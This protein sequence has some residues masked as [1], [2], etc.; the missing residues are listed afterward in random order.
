MIQTDPLCPPQ[1][2]SAFGDVGIFLTLSQSS[3]VAM[4]VTISLNGAQADSIVSV[5][6]GSFVGTLVSSVMTGDLTQNI[7]QIIPSS[8]G[9]T[10]NITTSMQTLVYN[11]SIVTLNNAQ[12]TYL[13]ASSQSTGT[14]PSVSSNA[15]TYDYVV[16]FLC[17]LGTVTAT[18]AGGQ[19]QLWNMQTGAGANR[20]RSAGATKS[21]AYPMTMSW[22]L[23]PSADY[24]TTMLTVRGYPYHVGVP[25]NVA[26][27]THIGTPN[28][29][30]TPTR[31]VFP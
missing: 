22:T 27:P 17:A 7:Y 20:L 28:H 25:N 11:Y 3:A 21:P 9:D 15:L 14:A 26:V 29:V 18:N 19:T 4:F 8:L 2:A 13:I 30:A 31:I 12:A 1:S 24:V 5:S 23:S 10:L 6:L 16:N